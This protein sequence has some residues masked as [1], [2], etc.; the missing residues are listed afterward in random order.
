ME[1][2]LRQT[3]RIGFE[4]VDPTTRFGRRRAQAKSGWSRSSLGGREYLISAKNEAGVERLLRDVPGSLLTRI[5]GL[6]VTAGTDAG[7]VAAFAFN[8][9]QISAELEALR[10]LATT[11]TSESH[12]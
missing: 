12:G 1:A 7:F 2:T 6:R 4:V 5:E 11:I 9:G 10:N 8:A 3:P